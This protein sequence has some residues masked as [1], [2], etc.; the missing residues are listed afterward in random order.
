MSG[1]RV[2]Q[3]DVARAANVSISTVSRALSGQGSMSP[4]VRERIRLIASE[5]GYAGGQRA[6]H[7]VRAVVYLPMHPVTGGLHQV[8]QDILDGARQAAEQEGIALFAKL[9]PEGAVDLACVERHKDAHDTRAALMFYTNPDEEVAA[10]FETQGAL[11]LVNT[12]DLRMRFDCVIANNYAGSRLATLKLIAQGHRRLLFV[13]GDLRLPWMERMRGFKDAI[14]ASAGVTGDVLEIGFDRH[15]T[16]L[17]HFRSLFAGPRPHDFTGIVCVNDLT[18]TGIMRAASELD[19]R[20]PEDVSIIGFEDLPFADMTTP[21]LSTIK[22]D[23]HAIGVESIRLLK[24]R[25][26]DRQAIA[27][28]IQQGVQFIEGGTIAAPPVAC[29]D[30]V[31]MRRRSR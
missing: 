11:I 31:V 30:P 23:R 9:L 2:N 12:V 15:E 24:R 10:Y 4:E 25:L 16:A 29:S 13:T 22:V 7:A 27:L 21:R 6:D 17:A 1:R 3:V 26:A 8:F 19:I 18:A 28:Q 20:I 5:L 14:A